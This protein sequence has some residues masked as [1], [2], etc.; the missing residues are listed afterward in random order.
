MRFAGEPVTEW[1]FEGAAVT[2][3]HVWGDLTAEGPF[4]YETEVEVGAGGR[5]LTFEGASYAAE[6]WV[7]GA[8]V[9][10]RRGIWDA[11]AVRLEAVRRADSNRRAWGKTRRA[12]S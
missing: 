10:E 3:P 4:V 11:F 7:D 8:C 12:R 5:W 6:V 9:L 1:R 2:V